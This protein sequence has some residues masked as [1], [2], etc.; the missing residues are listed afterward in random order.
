MAQVG[1]QRRINEPHASGSSWVRRYLEM[2]M[3]E[4]TSP[5]ITF[6]APKVLVATGM[7]ELSVRSSWG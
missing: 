2:I 7:P 3:A 1:N 4:G 6:F 5:D